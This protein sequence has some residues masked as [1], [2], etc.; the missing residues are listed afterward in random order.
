[1]IRS[2]GPEFGLGPGFGCLGH[3]T[4]QLDL[5]IGLLQTQNSSK[6]GNSVRGGWERRCWSEVAATICQL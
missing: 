2:P 4:G 5:E 1:M 3:N 6:T